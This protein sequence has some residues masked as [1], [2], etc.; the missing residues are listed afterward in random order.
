[1]LNQLHKPGD[2]L[3]TFGGNPVSCAAAL[4]NI[5][6]MEQEKLPARAFEAGQYALS[7]LG[8]LKN[9]NPLIGD[10]RGRGLMIGVELVKDADRTPA[11][12]EAEAIRDECLRRGLLVGVGGVYA[13]VI[14]FQPPLVITNQQLDQ[15]FS[16]FSEALKAV[17]PPAKAAGRHC[18]L[19]RTRPRSQWLTNGGVI[20]RTD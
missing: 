1:M 6:F 5:E 2:R 13:N 14:R 10:V 8:E 9:R 16:I 15:A 3:T 19:V 4:A 7:K 18:L 20:V 12:A 17:R 11:P